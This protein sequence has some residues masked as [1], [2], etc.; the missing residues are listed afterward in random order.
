MMHVDVSSRGSA[1]VAL[2]GI[3]T[4]ASAAGCGGTEQ[5]VDAVKPAPTPAAAASDAS[6]DEPAAPPTA[7]DG[8]EFVDTSVLLA[9]QKTAFETGFETHEGGL[10]GFEHLRA[11]SMMFVAMHDALNAIRPVFKQYAYTGC[12]PD[13]HPGAATAQAAHDVMTHAFPKLKD[14]FDKELAAQLAAL[15]E[16]KGKETGVALGKASAAAIIAM[17]KDDGML[18]DAKYTPKPPEPGNYQFIPPLDFV[19]KPTFGDAKTFALSSG[20]DLRPPPPPALESPQYAKDYNEVKAVGG[21]KS[22]KRTKDQTNYATWWLESAEGTWNRFAADVTVERKLDVY[23]A[24]R[25]FAMLNIGLSDATVV[26]WNAKRYYD[27]W[28]PATAIRGAAKDKNDGTAP[29]AKWESL[30]MCPPVQEYPSAHAIQSATATSILAFALGTDD[31]SFSMETVTAPPD[32]KKRS[33][34][35]LSEAAAEAADSR[36]M[37]GFHFRYSLDVGLDMGRKIGAQVVE[38]Q[39]TARASK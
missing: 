19:Y 30:H 35:K 26:I 17:R 6:C 20:K 1:A 38:T 15:P 10:I 21:K 5:Q 32:G 7:E 2:A 22:K 4:F 39:C 14:R 24:A 31:V 3:L 25:M 8:A 33:F 9:W 23:T 29:D 28:R 12:Q 27:T 34:K 37:A 11:W 16:G 36:V 13:A 18:V